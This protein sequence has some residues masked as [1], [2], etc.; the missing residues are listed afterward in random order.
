[1][2]SNGKRNDTTRTI[3]QQSVDKTREE[4]LAEARETSDGVRLPSSSKTLWKI[5]N[6]FYA[7]TGHETNAVV[8]Q[9]APFAGRIAPYEQH[10]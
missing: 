8:P 4:V 7:A 6:W 5:A 9:V 2:P 3:A 1:M 10:G